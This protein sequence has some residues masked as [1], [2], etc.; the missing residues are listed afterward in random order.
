MKES[1]ITIHFD[2]ESEAYQ[3]LSEKKPVAGQAQAH[4]PHKNP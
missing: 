4:A 1:V 3:A 2:V